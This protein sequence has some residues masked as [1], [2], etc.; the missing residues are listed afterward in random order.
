MPPTIVWSV[1]HV[2]ISS[3]RKLKESMSL[4]V[5]LFTIESTKM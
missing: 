1:P 5:I 2:A 3:D 4:I